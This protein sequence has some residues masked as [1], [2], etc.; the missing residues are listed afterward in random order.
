MIKDLHINSPELESYVNKIPRSH[1]RVVNTRHRGVYY[2]L[3][4]NGIGCIFVTDMIAAV[5]YH[6]SQSV[7]FVPIDN[8][9]TLY[10]I[11]KKNRILSDEEK[12]FIRVLGSVCKKENLLP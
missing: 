9:R 10:A 6:R 2:D 11:Y 5:E 8:K 4:L 12:S 7:R 1:C 3:M